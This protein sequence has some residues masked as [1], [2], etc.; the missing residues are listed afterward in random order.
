MDLNELS[1][2]LSDKIAQVCALKKWDKDWLKGGCYIHL[3]VSEFIESLRGK[4]NDPPEKEAAD[5]MFTLLA[6]MNHY[7]IS[8][9][10]VLKQLNAIIDG[11]LN[12][13]PCD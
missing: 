7:N 10:A 11:H 6:V 4:G 13:Q 5:V 2:K 1:E 12:T 9:E 3:E 8:I